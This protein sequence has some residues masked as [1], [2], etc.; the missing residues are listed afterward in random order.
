MR[1]H[2]SRTR[3]GRSGAPATVDAEEVTAV[4]VGLF[5]GLV[6]QRRARRDQVPDEL[7]ATALRWLLGG[8]KGLPGTS[9]DS[10]FL[11]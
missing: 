5:H 2:A 6:R 11:A 4:V 8:I 10:P 9:P 3:V 7:F 1:H